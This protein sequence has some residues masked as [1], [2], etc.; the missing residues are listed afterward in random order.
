MS[1][2]TGMLSYFFD[3]KRRLKACVDELQFTE[4]KL[5]RELQEKRRRH[6]KTTAKIMKLLDSGNVA[7]A[8]TQAQ[9]SVMTDYDIRTTLN[10]LSQIS[11][12]RTAAE[13]AM[14]DM[15]MKKATTTVTNAMSTIDREKANLILDKFEA[16]NKDMTQRSTKITDMS[17]TVHVSES[18]MDPQSQLSKDADALLSRISAQ[19]SLQQATTLGSAPQSLSVD[20]VTGAIA[21]ASNA[22]HR[23]PPPPAET[24]GNDSPSPNET[25][26]SLT[27]F[28]MRLEALLRG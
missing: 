14:M 18:V 22:P 19:Y 15:D 8:R 27:D 10:M 12:I 6:A 28:E 7:Q 3:P 1:D 11:V 17:Q 24:K 9:L 13:R 4:F 21:I 16:F 2:T 25:S 26:S 5:E 20:E 23:A